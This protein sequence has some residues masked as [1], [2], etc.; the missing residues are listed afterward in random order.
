METNEDLIIVDNTNSTLKEYAKYKKMAEQYEYSV[1]II[2]MYC[3]NRE[4]AIA[5]ASRNCHNV[6]IT[7]VLKMLARW[8]N[9]SDAIIVP[10]S[11]NKSTL[12]Q[13]ESHYDTSF[14][15]WLYDNKLIHNTK[16]RQYTHLEYG[17][18]RCSYIDI[19]DE[20]YYEFLER[21]LKSPT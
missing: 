5:F 2:E 1:I 6:P 12:T 19:P 18:E 4:Q 21:Y 13:N 8:E 7:N 16:Q 10:C 17:V 3:E 9:D 20:L 11:T 14:H 15:K